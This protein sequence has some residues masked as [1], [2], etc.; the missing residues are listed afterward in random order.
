D[1]DARIAVGDGLVALR[2]RVCHVTSRHPTFAQWPPEIAGSSSFRARWANRPDSGRSARGLG[3]TA[4][5]LMRYGLAKMACLAALGGVLY[6]GAL[7]AAAAS[8]DEVYTV[9]NYPVD[10]QAANAVAAK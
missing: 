9:G 4:D 7:P 5:G 3:R 2:T 6:W 1:V 10:A 8:G